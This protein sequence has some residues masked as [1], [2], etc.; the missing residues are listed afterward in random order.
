M[1][2]EIALDVV[3]W[4][5][6]LR[7][8][9]VEG[10]TVIV[11]DVLRATSTIVV[12]LHAG[13]RAVAVVG[14]VSSARKRAK[15]LGADNCVFGG[16]RG[17]IKIPR[18]SFGNSPLEYLQANPE[19]ISGKTL[20][21]T[22]TNGTRAVLKSRRAK[23]VFLG[24]TIN[25]RATA[26]AALLAGAD[27]TILCAGTEGKFSADDFLA[28]G[29]LVDRIVQESKAMRGGGSGRPEGGPQAAS[30]AVS[31]PGVAEVRP[32]LSDGAMVALAYWNENRDDPEADLKACWHGR[33]MLRL[34]FVED[35]RFC[36]QV[37]VFD[38]VAA[39]HRETGLVFKA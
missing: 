5:E 12:A 29:V 25:A 1:V 18:F 13:F 9:D 10:R 19:R 4:S 2:K 27:V 38:L 36:S 11:V 17:G 24:S 34:G 35:I 22:T 7:P 14:S 23:T 31:E 20:V 6:L 8:A 32:R 3:F 39:F 26:R 21:F 28:A 16:E 15:A 37:D 33:R 30:E